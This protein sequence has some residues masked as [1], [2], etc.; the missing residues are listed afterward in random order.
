MFLKKKVFFTL[1]LTAISYLVS[2][3]TYSLFIREI[4]DFELAQLGV[5]ENFFGWL[6]NLITFG[7]Q[8]DLARRLVLDPSKSKELVSEAKRNLFGFG[9]VLSVISLLLLPIIGLSVNIL[10]LIGSFVFA[11]NVDFALYGINKPVLAGSLSLIRIIVPNSF[12]LIAVYFLKIE[13]GVFYW[14]L[15]GLILANFIIAII[16]SKAL[17]VPLFVKPN[18]NFFTVALQLD[19]KM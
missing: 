18:F 3:G 14:F 13:T 9:I 11:L 2:I 7:I 5:I 10:I 19:V 15:F 6:L 4:N 8:I 16:S 12:A 17:K 1:L